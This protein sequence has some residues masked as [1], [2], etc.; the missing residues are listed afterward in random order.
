MDF[1]IAKLTQ[2]QTGLT[3]TGMTLGTAAYLA[4][5][6]IRGESVDQRTDIFSFGVLAYELLTFQR[7]FLGDAISNVL[8]QILNARAR[9]IT[10]FWPE[11]PPELAEAGRPLH[12]EGPGQAV[13]ELHRA[14][15]RSRSDPAQGAQQGP[16]VGRAD[17]Q[18][19]GA[20]LH[21]RDAQRADRAPA[22]R[23]RRR[24]GRGRHAGRGAGARLDAPPRPAAAHAQVDRRLGD[25]SPQ[26]DQLDA[27]GG[28]G[29]GGAGRR[30]Q[31]V[32]HHAR[33]RAAARGEHRRHRAG[34]ETASPA[35]SSEPAAPPAPPAVPAAEA[36]PAPPPPAPS[37][38]PAVP[39]T[40][41]PAGPPTGA[42]AAPRRPRRPRRP[43][44]PSR[45]R[46]PA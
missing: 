42:A 20:R 27:L 22:A 24:G 4:P 28:A 45:R 32:V 44:R 29:A 3:Q 12:G 40:E 38:A 33:P 43:S 21:H 1:G 10:E 30:R 8:Y 35:E 6:Q 36:A 39:S 41:V 9:P 14:A 5:E 26:A 37:A 11:C 25:P 23:R 19:V 7:P 34:E 15:P 18:H 16:P 2:R 13:R 17:E 31:L 46:R